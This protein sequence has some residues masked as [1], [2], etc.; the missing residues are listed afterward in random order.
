MSGERE[1]GGIGYVGLNAVRLLG[2]RV[3]V[4]AGIDSDFGSENRYTEL[5]LGL[6]WRLSEPVSLKFGYEVRNEQ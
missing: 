5:T 3:T 4:E 1:T 6:A 2:E